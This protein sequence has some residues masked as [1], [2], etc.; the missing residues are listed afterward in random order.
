MSAR[1]RYLPMPVAVA[2]A[3]LAF[4]ASASAATSNFSGTVANGGCTTAQTVPVSGPSRIAV[5]L[6]STAQN[7]S[8]VDANI[9][10]PDGRVV[11]GGGSG[12]SYDT[13]GGGTYS[14]QVCAIYEAQN[15]PQVQFNGI[16]GTGPAGQPALTGPEQPQPPTGGGGVKGVQTTI[17]PSVR[18]KAAIMTRAGLAWF[19]VVTGSNSKLTLRFVD[20]IHHMT[21]LVS[22]LTATSS[23]NTVRI[24]GHGLILALHKGA[25]SQRVS[26]S[27]SRFKATG[28]V[29]RGGFKI[30]V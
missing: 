2:I 6:A 18:G 14:V 13:P 26:F 30:A 7:N 1:L 25:G 22:G 9:V 17:G 23:G 11:A 3:C 16:L 24:T 20:P 4:A 8:E 27:S 15:P 21:R 12:A 5:R 28:R 10:A 29:V 19:T